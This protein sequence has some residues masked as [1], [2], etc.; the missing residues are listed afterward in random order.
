[1]NT[2]KIVGIPKSQNFVLANNSNNKVVI[3]R[4][5]FTPL[6]FATNGMVGKECER[7]LKTLVGRVVEK[8]GD[9]RYSPLSG[10][11]PSSYE[12]DDVHPPMEYHVFSWLPFIVHPEK[13]ESVSNSVPSSLPKINFNIFL[14]EM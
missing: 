7:F 9:L 12:T 1:M 6:V 3:D 5:S 8:N 13:V 4:G 10:D 2:R 14:S 11:E